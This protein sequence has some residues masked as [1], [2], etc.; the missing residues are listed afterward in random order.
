MDQCCQEAGKRSSASE[1]EVLREHPR[2]NVSD[3]ETIISFLGHIFYICGI[4]TIDGRKAEIW[5]FEESFFDPWREIN[6]LEPF[7]LFEETEH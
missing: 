6:K 5:I 1:D 3:E 2:G 4:L 7:I